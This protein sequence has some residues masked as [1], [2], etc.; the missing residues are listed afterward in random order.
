M[1]ETELLRKDTEVRQKI[2]ETV[3]QLSCQQDV[4]ESLALFLSYILNDLA[5][6][7]D[8]KYFTALDGSITILKSV[9][10]ELEAA[11]D[12]LDEMLRKI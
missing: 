2:N 9:S 4:C 7:L 5:G 10:K 12:G 1:E 3:Y 6:S 11:Y 8:L